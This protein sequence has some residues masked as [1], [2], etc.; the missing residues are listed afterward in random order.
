ARVRKLASEATTLAIKEH[1]REV[2]LEY[3]RLA[4][5]VDRDTARNESESR[6][7]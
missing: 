7:E 2:A 6:S 4:E 5:R 3:E 1:L